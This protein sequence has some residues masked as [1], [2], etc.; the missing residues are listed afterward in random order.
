MR[1]R[2]YT[3]LSVV[4]D[5]D[6]VQAVQAEDATG[7]FGILEGHEDVVTT[8]ALSVV[9]WTEADGTVRYCAVRGGVLLVREG[10]DVS[11][12]T[13]EAVVGTDLERLHDDVLERLASAEEAERTERFESTRLHL[14]AIREITQQL[15]HARRQEGF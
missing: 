14:A 3:P 1:L 4:V 2:I 15:R 12:A 5:R 13:R 11:V 9:R 7:S 6:G 8:L 10:E